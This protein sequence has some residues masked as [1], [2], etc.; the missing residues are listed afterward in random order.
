MHGAAP[1]NEGFRFRPWPCSACTG[2]STP[3]AHLFRGIEAGSIISKGSPEEI[4]ESQVGSLQSW[5]ESCKHTQTTSLILPELSSGSE[6]LVYFE[7]TSLKVVKTTR[8]DIFGE[9]YFLDLGIMTQRNC[10][11]L[12]YLIRL[13]WWKKLFRSAPEDIGITARGQIVSRQD[14]ITGDLPTQE[15]VDEFLIDSGLLAV[16]QKYWLW[17]KTY[18]D[19]EIWIGDARSDN[20]VK[21]DHGVVPIDIRTWLTGV[22]E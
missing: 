20:F 2:G 9:S 22:T 16:R 11:P 14:F 10:S 7:E 15:S 6:H 1:S 8:P 17:K 12:E 13:H 21:T 5:V 18:T 3:I 19:F 4:A